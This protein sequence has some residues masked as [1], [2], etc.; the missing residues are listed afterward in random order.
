LIIPDGAVKW[1]LSNVVAQ[2][3]LR[4]RWEIISKKPLTICDTGHNAHGFTHSMQQ[5][6]AMPCRRLHFVFGVVDDK[7]LDSLLPL[8][9]PNAYYYF[10]KADIPRAMDAHE[11]AKRCTAYGLQGQ[12]VQT[13]PNAMKIARGNALSDDIIFVGGSSF[14]VAE[15]LP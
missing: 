10:T 12:I 1:G 14:V 4:G 6:Q 3:G 13:V 8:M 11:L 9:P 7:D 15:A 5:L 2:T